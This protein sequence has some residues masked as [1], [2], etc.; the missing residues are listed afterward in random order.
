MTETFNANRDEKSIV[1]EYI[2]SHWPNTIRHEPNDVG[3]LIGLPYPY[4]VPC[5]HEPTMQNNFYWDTYFTNVGLLRQGFI[6]LAKNN[7]DN[8]LFEVEK[9]G[10]VPNGNRTFFLTRSQAP[11]LSLMIKDIYAAFQDRDWLRSAF[12]TWRKEYDF[13]LQTR[14][15]PIGLNRYFH[16]ATNA[17][18]LEF[19]ADE[20]KHRPKTEV[21]TEG[22]QL[23]I[24]AHLLAEAES[25]WDFTPRF[26]QRCAD[27]APVDLNSLLYLNE[28]NAA[29][30]CEI[31]DDPEKQVWLERAQRRLKLIHDFCWN[32]KG[33]LFYDYDFVHHRQS[34]VASLATF[35][36]LWTRLA[37]GQQ[38]R[39][40]VSNLHR[41][42]FDY[43]VA[44]CEN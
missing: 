40:I 25:G 20:L 14:L 44:A 4:T 15:T 36:P 34:L 37:T 30:F 12:T 5:Q 33:G 43:G 32:K 10:F 38:A 27:F 17:Q 26:E 24:S 3:N 21:D 2:R 18:L 8:L 31:L 11:F 19:Y 13:W 35:V 22:Q 16:H 23:A 7:V 42:E 29:Y 41:F 9:F 6:E 1:L 39:M 28:V